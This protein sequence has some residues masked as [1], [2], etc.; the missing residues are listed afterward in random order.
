MT[1]LDFRHWAVIVILEFMVIPVDLVRK[2]VNNK[3]VGGKK[4]VN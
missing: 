2:V 4:N 1:A 3:K